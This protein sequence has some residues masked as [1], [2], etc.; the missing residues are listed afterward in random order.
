M[1]NQSEHGESKSASELSGLCPRTGSPHCFS[2]DPTFRCVRARGSVT[3]WQCNNCFALRVE[4]WVDSSVEPFRVVVPDP[5]SLQ[6][7]DE[8]QNV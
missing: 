3:V 8:K 2:R 7:R 6:P 5:A 1:A 4:S